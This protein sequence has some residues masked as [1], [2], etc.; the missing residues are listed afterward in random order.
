MGDLITE[1]EFA[2]IYA[3]TASDN[4]LKLIFNAIDVDKNG[5]I[6]ALEATQ[7]NTGDTVAGVD[8]LQAEAQ[9]QLGQLLDMGASMRDSVSG[10]A[11]LDGSIISLTAEIQRQN[12]RAENDKLIAEQVA[13]VSQK[14]AIAEDSAASITAGISAGI[15]GIWALGRREN[16]KLGDN[17][18]NDGDRTDAYFRF[19]ESGYLEYEF[20]EIFGQLKDR[21]QFRAVYNRAGGLRDQTIGQSNALR[22]AVDL[23]SSLEARLSDLKVDGSHETGLASVPFDGYIGRLHKDEGVIDARTMAGMRKYGIPT[24]SSNNNSQILVELRQINQRLAKLDEISANSLSIAYSTK[25]SAVLAQTAEN[26]GM[27]VEIIN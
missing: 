23:V 12:Q 15:S 21:E 16:L 11:V 24:S 7:A 8:P 25:E 19:G 20:G 4:Q 22:K 5:V 9:K 17:N 18:W 6:S 3:G 13:E 26:V 2:S 1:R 27:R 10:I 14:L